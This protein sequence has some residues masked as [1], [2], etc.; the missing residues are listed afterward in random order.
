MDR[1]MQDGMTQEHANRECWGGA[2]G[3]LAPGAWVEQLEPADRADEA[4]A[5]M[6]WLLRTIE[7]EIIPRLMLAHQT[8]RLPILIDDVSPP[9]LGHED[10]VAFAAL[11]LSQQAGAAIAQVEVLRAQ[12]VALEAL[13]LD[14]LAPAARHLGELWEAD[15]CDFTQVTLGLWRLQQVMHELSPAFQN[16][17]TYSLQRRRVLLAPAPGSQHTLGLFMVAEFFRRAGWD[18]SAEP[19]ASAAELA[20][21]DG[22]DWFDV[23]GLSMGTELQVEADGRDSGAAQGVA[24]QGHR[25]HGR[26]RDIH[27][28]P[29]PRRRRRCRR[30]GVRCASGSRRGRDLCRQARETVLMPNRAAAWCAGCSACVQRA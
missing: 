12:G 28:G 26:W 11:V 17:A 24:E 20:A 30:D 21:A 16:E 2:Q 18:V 14:L 10:V 4:T 25:H 3:A 27:V 29:R 13:Y 8:A 5:R 9:T 23:V 7:A 1:M 6:T 22:R 15:L 19:A